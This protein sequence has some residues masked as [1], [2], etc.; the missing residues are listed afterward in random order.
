MLFKWKNKTIFIVLMRKSGAVSDE[1]M[2]VNICY[3]EKG[4]NSESCTLSIGWAN[5]LYA[6]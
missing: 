6:K 5:W 3:T 2:R 4:F 1:E